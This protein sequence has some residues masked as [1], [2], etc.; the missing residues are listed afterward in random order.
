MMPRR[1]IQVARPHVSLPEGAS[2]NKDGALPHRRA[3]RER[4]DVQLHRRSRDRVTHESSRF[5]RLLRAGSLLVVAVASLA[6]VPGAHAH[7]GTRSSGYVSSFSSLD[8]SVVGVLVNV[9]GSHNTIQLS[10]YSD[11]AV[12]V[13][14]RG[15]EPY[16]RF[17][18][19]G[20]AENV[21]SP[22]TYL[23]RSRVVPAGA[24]PQ[25]KP[26]WRKVAS[27]KGYA[28]HDHRIVWTGASP[29]AIVEQAPDVSHL[30]FSWSLPATAGGKPFLIKGFLGW[31]A[32][33]PEDSGTS[34]WIYGAAFAVAALAVALALVLAS[35]A[36][37]ARQRAL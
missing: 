3:P 22:T 5:R 29:P 30:I 10:N 32:A 9:F 19:A 15:G 18:R 31:A 13:L 4:D 2:I 37:R 8:P 7:G 21:R 6:A 35:R 36:R 17:T 12:V 16:L 26:L 24:N 20:V 28:W 34:G 25:A 11:N 27:G 23:N 1:L 33:K 14:G